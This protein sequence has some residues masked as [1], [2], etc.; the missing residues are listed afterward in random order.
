[1]YGE[2]YLKKSPLSVLFHK[3]NAKVFFSRENSVHLSY[4]RRG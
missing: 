3:V 4:A 2:I 1:M